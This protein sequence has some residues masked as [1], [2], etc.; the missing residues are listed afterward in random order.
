MPKG[1]NVA[2]LRKTCKN[3]YKKI[4]TQLMNCEDSLSREN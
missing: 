2:G 4:G 1:E 3:S